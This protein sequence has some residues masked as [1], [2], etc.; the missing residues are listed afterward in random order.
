[1]PSILERLRKRT[2]SQQSSTSTPPTL[3]PPPPQITPVAY[4]APLATTRSEPSLVDR[5][6]VQDLP[7]L[8]HAL[9]RDQG[10]PDPG[11]LKPPRTRKRSGLAGLVLN[12]KDN[13]DHRPESTAV[14]AP[15]KENDERS[16]D[17]QLG[18]VR[19]TKS[20]GKG[21]QRSL[22]ASRRYLSAAASPWSTFG[23]QRTRSATSPSA[24]AQAPRPGSR[25]RASTVYGPSSSNT[26]E[27]L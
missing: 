26:G 9:E 13:A 7:A 15:E 6:I 4:N 16:S 10:A 1:M 27:W 11:A 20:T 3:A 21:K 14:Q 18:S 24:F 25:S 2:L 22:G 19:S 12:R 23:R 8:L 5:R 17:S